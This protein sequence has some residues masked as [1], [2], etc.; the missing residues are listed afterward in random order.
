MRLKPA[1]SLLLSLSTLL[2]LVPPAHAQQTAAAQADED[3]PA[4]LRFR[5]SEEAAPAERPTP[6]AS[7][8]TAVPLPDAETERLLARLPA[9]VQDGQDARDLRLRE[10]SL[11]PPRAGAT[12]HAAFADPASD[13]PAPP[14]ATSEPLEVSRF[15]PSGEVELAP[16][17]SV[18][19]SQPMVAVSSHGE[20]GASV[21]AALTPRPA[22]RWRWLGSRTLLFSPEDEGGRLPM[23]TDYVVHV[24]AGTRSAL[25]NALREPFSFRFSTPPPTL[26]ASYP[27]GQSLPRDAPMFVEFDQRVDAARVLERLRVEPAARLR[28]ATPEEVASDEQL[29]ALAKSAQAGRWLAFRAVNSNGSTKDALPP[30]S[31]IKIV[32]AAGTPS[33]EGPRTT[34][35]EQSFTFKTFGPLLVTEADCNHR[36]LCG[37]DEGFELNFSN[38]LDEK[39]L[40]A[41]KVSVSPA[42]PGAKVVVSGYAIRVEGEKRPDTVYTVTLDRSLRDVFGQTLTG[43]NQFT[44][45]VAARPPGVFS[46]VEGFAVLDPA[47]RRAFPVYSVGYRRLKVSVR[48]VGPEDWAQFRRHQ[49]ERFYR[50][51]GDTSKPPVQPPG[52]VVFD[53]VVEVKGAPNDITET[54]FDLAPALADGF[55]HAFVRIEGVEDKDAP[56]RIYAHRPDAR[57]EG[58]VQVTQIG[59]DAF[60]DRDSLTAWANSL[61]DGRPLAGVQLTL[62]PEGASQQSGADGLARFAVGPLAESGRTPRLLVARRG[63]DVALLPESHSPYGGGAWRRYDADAALAWYVFDD[64]KLYRPGEEVSVKGW[65]RRTKLTPTGDTELFDT[66]GET[67]S[68][69]LKDDRGN[70]ITKGSAR[71]NPL[72]G[73]DL[74]LKLPPT[75]NL[76]EAQLA[77]KL[78]RDGGRH[79]HR[80]SV[81]EFRRPEFELTARASEAPH[82]V[83]S[84]ASVTAEANYYTGGGL[85]DTEINWR[86]HASPTNYTP[87]NRDD[88][89]FGKFVPWWGGDSADGETTEQ[90]FKGRTDA[91]GRHKLRLD[92]ES[93]RPPRPSSV[94]VEARVQ[95][96]NRQTLAAQARLL[97]HP[98]DVYVG[99]KSAR[100]FV[101]KGEAFEINSVV[102][103]LDGRAL[104]GRDVRLRLARVEHVYE[105]GRWTSREVDAQERVVRSV[106]GAASARCAAGEGGVYRL[107][108]RVRDA[109]ERENESELTLWVAGGVRPPRRDVEREKVE[110]IPD[111]KSYA[112]GDVAEILVQS[113][114]GPA[115]GVLTLRRT[116]L[117]RTERFTLKEGS[118]TLRVPIEEAMTPNVHVQVDLVG[119]A[120]RTDD[121]GEPLPELPR[122]PAYASGELSLSVPPVARRLSVAATPRDAVLEPGRET[123]VDV[124]VKDA[125][126]APAA[127]TD[128]AVVV[129]DEAVLA[130]TQY[131]LEDPLAVFYPEREE[132]ASDYHLRDALKLA[133]PEELVR[134]PQNLSAFRLPH[135]PVKN[136]SFRE[137]MDA[138]VSYIMSAQTEMVTV[139]SDAPGADTSPLA[140]RRNFGALAVFAASVP[141]DAAGRAQVRVK[142]PDSLTR[143]RVMAVSVAGGRLAGA[144]ES[145]ITARLPLMAR[146]SPPRFLNFGDRVELPVVVQNQTDAPLETSV[147][148][149]ATNAELT[150]PAGV[151]V[152]VPARERVEVRFPF[153]ARSAGTAR[154]QIVAAS[155]ERA[156]SAEISLPVHTPASTEAFAT[157][158]VVDEGSVAQPVKAPAGALAQFGGLEVTTSSTQLQELTDAFLYLHQYPFDCSEQ[159]ASRVLAVAALK[160]ALAAFNSKELPSPEAMRASAAADLKRLA[161]LQNPDGGFAFWRRGDASFPFVSVHVAHALARARAAGFAVPEGL[162]ERSHAYLKEVERKIPAYYS[163][164]SRRA[165]T[166][167]ALHVRALLK[168]SDA[169]RARRLVAE[170]GGV[171]KLSLESLGWL[172]PVLAP[173]PA[174]RQETESLRRHLNNRVTE[175]AGAAHFADRYSDGQYIILHSDRRADAVILDALIGDQ[176]QSDLIPKLVRGLLNQRRKGR[177][178]NT[179]EN[180]FAL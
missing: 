11:P 142:L 46:P 135:L 101:Q 87:P 139:T 10:N 44:F 156:D 177:C 113:P 27:T 158:G 81:Q 97:V 130:L 26:K 99:L 155:G 122:R 41:S 165:I 40:P 85:A 80:L 100:T 19:F 109:R 3:K 116:G 120:V 89:T 138:D 132:G 96:V 17:L 157:Y 102:T 134:A 175:T 68:Y 60:A 7:V 123:F 128:T 106:E 115:E 64:R 137:W 55:G 117:L 24:P 176:P 52:R 91:S 67:L 50:R 56:V 39:S 2:S 4:G 69:V 174:S 131:K 152:N 71:L 66:R 73:F 54:M 36:G 35:A 164:E 180:V 53:R 86:V 88:Y 79:T 151:R 118:H 92:F 159:M 22:G 25:G 42:L 154:F 77:F 76:G 59:L 45:K 166:A 111:R 65:V 93:V 163:P 171:E 98:A 103:D 29:S 5:L 119:S 30:D 51:G 74:K 47:A 127:G 162:S 108:A 170:A 90:S 31:T 95:D 172:L 63:N 23:A 161:A 167:Y 15:A 32:L 133:R 153:A 178:S 147:A 49:H 13:A 14:V 28:L 9:V 125:R 12:L 104:A 143:Y 20:A 94:L 129:V 84:N 168:D 110:L 83:G 149:R 72:A 62:L 148:V 140:P 124:L 48:K 43:Q 6:R 136:R 112:G 173:D 114:F 34:A 18:T 82:F 105:G 150:G 141:T 57:V 58:W 144:G 126:G 1:L 169:P 16:G 37:T 33:A 38:A 146:P 121:D 61:S 70:E 75:M 8:P 179:Q 21:P 78:E 145:N 160:D 107:T